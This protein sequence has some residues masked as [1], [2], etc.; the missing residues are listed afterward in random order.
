MQ[1]TKES[2][3]RFSDEQVLVH[4]QHISVDSILRLARL[5]YLV[6]FLQKAP[7]PLINL[8]L[9]QISYKNSWICLVQNDLFCLWNSNDSLYSTMPN[10]QD[11][12]AEWVQ[13]IFDSPVHWRSL[14]IKIINRSKGSV[15]PYQVIIPAVPAVAAENNSAFCACYECGKIFQTMAQ[16]RTHQFKM[17]Q[18][19]NPVHSLVYT[20]SCVSCGCEYHHRKFLIKHLTNR[21]ASNLCR[22]YYFANVQPMSHEQLCEVETSQPCLD[23]KALR[24]PPIPS[25]TA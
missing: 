4:L 6:R 2:S 16:L 14:F 10:P 12:I 21:P 22:D 17:H 9:L 23:P 25:C 13:D 19:R 3:R 18:Y 24:C 7:S 11:N 15:F 1:N 20:T 8:A 5:R